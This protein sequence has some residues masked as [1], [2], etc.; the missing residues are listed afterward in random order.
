MHVI[1]LPFSHLL[2]CAVFYWFILNLSILHIFVNCVLPIY[3]SI[4][5]INLH[6]FCYIIFCLTPYLWVVLRYFVFTLDIIMF[7][8]FRVYG[9][10][11]ANYGWS[12][13]WFSTAYSVISIGIASFTSLIYTHVFVSYLHSISNSHPFVVFL[14]ILE[15]FPVKPLYFVTALPS[16][17][18]STISLMTKV[19][20][21][22]LS[23]W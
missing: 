1:Y 19:Y 17:W 23:N 20:C 15:C 6:C 10:H 9:N 5:L 11:Q 2:W 18:W 13:I 7:L 21:P 22:L 3:V 14:G 4:F 12:D 8:L 16:L